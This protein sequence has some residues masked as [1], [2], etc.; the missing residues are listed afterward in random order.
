MTVD[1]AC[2]AEEAYAFMWDPQSIFLLEDDVVHA[3]TLPG[4]PA[5]QILESSR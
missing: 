4:T 1:L 2:S 5:R 3:V